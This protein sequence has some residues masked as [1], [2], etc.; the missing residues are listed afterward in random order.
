MAM[1]KR[2]GSRPSGVT[3]ARG[4]RRPVLVAVLVVVAPVVNHVTGLRPL[5]TQVLPEALLHGLART[6]LLD[7]W[8]LFDLLAASGVVGA[9]AVV[10]VAGG[11]RLPAT[12]L[13]AAVAALSLAALLAGATALTLWYGLTYASA[14]LLARPRGGRS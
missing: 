3:W 4:F 13:L 12:V 14:A 1:R 6:G 9:L 8:L 7:P 5:W 11:V 2:A 10:M